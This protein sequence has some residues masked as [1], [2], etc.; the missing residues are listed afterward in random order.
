MTEPETVRNRY[1]GEPITDD[2]ATIAAA[3][4]DVSIPTLLLSMV[5]MT[6]DPILHPGRASCRSGIF[7]NEVQGFMTPEDAGRGAGPGARGD[8]APTATAAACCPRRRDEAL[9][10]EMMAC[11]VAE[12]RARRVRAR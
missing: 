12:R 5:H 10:H 2:D 7:L 4:E 1:A 8:L 6:G 3:L 11:L 9:L